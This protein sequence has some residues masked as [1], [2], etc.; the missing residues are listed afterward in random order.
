MLNVLTV[1]LFY[2]DGEAFI[3]GNK[4]PSVP[5]WVLD[6]RCP[7]DCYG[8]VASSVFSYTSCITFL[9]SVDSLSVYFLF[10]YFPNCS[11]CPCYAMSLC[12]CVYYVETVK[13]LLSVET[14]A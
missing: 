2:F 8:V 9:S 3:P 7:G 10:R 1:K 5:C 6:F 11:L 4:K 12:P 13:E 14:V